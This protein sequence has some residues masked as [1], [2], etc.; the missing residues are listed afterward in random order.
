[1]KIHLHYG[2]DGLNL[3][4][5]APNVTVIEPK[6]IDGLPDEQAAFQNAVRNPID[7]KPLRELIKATDMVAVV[8]PDITPR[9]RPNAYSRG[10]SQS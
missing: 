2:K 10:F 1:M 8:I 5:D 6:F 3:E 9:C 4:V 7:C